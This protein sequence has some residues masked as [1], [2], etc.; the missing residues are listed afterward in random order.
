VWQLIGGLQ[1]PLFANPLGKVLRTD[2]LNSVWRHAEFIRGHRS[3]HSSANNHLIGELAGLF[4]AG[5]TWPFWEEAKQWRRSARDGLEHEVATQNSEDGVNLEQATAYQQFV[6]DFLLMAE[7]AARATGKPFSERYRQRLE[8]MAEYVAAIMDSGGNVPMFGDAD[9][10]LVS[11]CPLGPA[12]APSRASSPPR[13]CSSPTRPWPARRAWSTCA[14]A[15]CWAARPAPSSTTCC[16]GRRRPR[17]KDFP[18]GG[19][20]VLGANLDTPTSSAWWPTP[21]PGPWRH[22]RPWARGRPVVH[23]VGGGAGVSGRSGHRHLPRPQAW[24]DGFRGTAMHNTL[25]IDGHDQAVSGGKFMWVRKYRSTVIERGGNR[26]LDKLVAEHDGYKRLPGK[27]AHRRSW[28]LDKLGDV[29]VVRDE[30]SGSRPSWW[31][32]TG[33]SA[34]SAASPAPPTACWWPTG[35]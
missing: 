35:R 29:L 17:R 2:W 30:I 33:T 8:A 20:F 4:V 12:A 15:G 18:E 9:D 14:P 27:P 31:R 5:A 22:R 11:G 28:E 32:S 1:S 24:R 26:V 10:G 19:M 13:R 25:C 23:A 16:C 7:L 3:G 6:W 34:R 21:A